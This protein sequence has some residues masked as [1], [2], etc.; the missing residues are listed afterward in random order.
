MLLRINYKAWL[1]QL[2]IWNAIVIFSKFLLFI[3]EFFCKV[4]LDKISEFLLGWIQ[5][6]PNLELI[7]V[8]I[9]VPVI[10]N[11]FAFW[12]QDNF[13]KKRDITNELEQV[14]AEIKNTQKDQTGEQLKE[15]Q[16]DKQVVES[17][18][19]ENELKLQ[20]KASS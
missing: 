7:F 4:I 1:L 5:K 10:M 19:I 11:G 18:K 20:K 15:N 2:V 9:V 14:E 13:L 6:Y 17:P 3:M 8:I 12:I 16:K